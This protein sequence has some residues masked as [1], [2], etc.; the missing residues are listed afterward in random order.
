MSYTL[1]SIDIYIDF[2]LCAKYL[3]VSLTVV[4]RA[5]LQQSYTFI[6]I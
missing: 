5:Y 3:T 4:I 6:Y 1:V 2:Q